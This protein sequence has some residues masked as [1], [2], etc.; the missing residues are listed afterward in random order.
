[1]LFRSPE[2]AVY[3]GYPL[4]SRAPSSSVEL[5]PGQEGQD[6]LE[7]VA[8]MYLQLALTVASCMLCFCYLLLLVLYELN[9]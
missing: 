2:E 1:M 7:E 9:E 3:A 4:R 5:Q 8:V 6:G